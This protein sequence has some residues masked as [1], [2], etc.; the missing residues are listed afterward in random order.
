MVV[1]LYI[2]LYSMNHRKSS[3]EKVNGLSAISLKLSSDLER[4]L[5]IIASPPP[6]PQPSSKPCS[7]VLND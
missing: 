3:Q 6:S 2:Y 1:Y 7:T 4:E 5:V